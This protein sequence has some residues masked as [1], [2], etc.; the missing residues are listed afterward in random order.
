[1][2]GLTEADVRRIVREESVVSVDL[3]NASLE[4]AHLALQRHPL[5][6]SLPVTLDTR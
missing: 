1:M 4:F 3:R 6:V 2:N 5:G